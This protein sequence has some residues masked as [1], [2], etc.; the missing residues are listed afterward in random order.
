MLKYEKYVHKQA[1][2]HEVG[3]LKVFTGDYA[4]R[5]TAVQTFHAKLML[6]SPLWDLL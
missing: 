6:L 4:E 5:Q 3:V 2:F 1:T